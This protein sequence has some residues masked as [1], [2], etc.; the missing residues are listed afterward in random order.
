MSPLEL[1][2]LLRIYCELGSVPEGDIEKEFCDH[3]SFHE[4]LIKRNGKY[5]PTARGYS[6]IKLILRT[7][8]PRVAYIGPDGKEILGD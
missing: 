7:P 1:R 5:E 4:I 8:F 6:F 3:L 2:C